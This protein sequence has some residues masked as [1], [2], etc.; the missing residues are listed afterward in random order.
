MLT[1]DAASDPRFNKADSIILTG[2]R[3][4]MGVPLVVSGKVLGMLC[5]S[6]RGKGL[7][8]GPLDLTLLSGIAAQASTSIE[9]AILNQRVQSDATSRAHLARFFSPALVELAASGALAVGGKAE[10]QDATILFADIRGF[11][12]MSERLQPGEVVDLLNEH[13]EAMVEIIFSN[14]GVLD[15][16][17]GD[18][19]MAL[20]GVPIR[21]PDEPV[22]ALKAANEML[23]RVKEMNVRRKARGAECFEIGIG[24]NTGAVVFGAIGASRRLELTAIGDAV[25]VAARLSQL[26][27]PGHVLIS[28]AT[29][30]LTS[31][32]FESAPM[33][34]VTM[35][36]KSHPVRVFEVTKERASAPRSAP[37]KPT[38]K[39]PSRG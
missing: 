14:G 18:A 3:S 23:L 11:S 29:A 12:A 28:E 31:R 9:N 20:W 34:P 27:A 13:F 36:G 8:L 7:T 4:A 15:K 22:R 30:G 24:V 1:V 35:K 37:P 33:P 17:I 16:F 5:L 39:S 21:Q 19:L 32:Q 25:N 2:L 26:A 10:A 6:T 38:R